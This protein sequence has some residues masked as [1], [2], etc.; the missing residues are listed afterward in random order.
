MV[1]I[2]IREIVYSKHGDKRMSAIG[3]SNAGSSYSAASAQPAFGQGS[4]SSSNPN[5]GQTPE[6]SD[7]F[8]PTSKKPQAQS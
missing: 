5:F 4:Q 7:T 8:T 6:S 1:F 3:P 2:Q